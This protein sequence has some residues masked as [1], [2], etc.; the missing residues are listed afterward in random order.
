MNKEHSYN[1]VINWTGNIGTGTSNYKA[2]NRSHTII[3]DGKTPILGSSD[4]AF[5]G[6]A[7]RYNPEEL[8]VSSISACHMLWYLHLCSVEGVIVTHYEDKAT[9][10]M[11]ESS[12]GGG[13]FTGVVLNPIV[14]VSKSSMIKPAMELHKK[15]NQLCYIA[16]SLNFKVHHKAIINSE[17]EEID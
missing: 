7:S 12:D 8:L 10:I 4:P 2:Y 17:I 1:T 15:A 6:D 14:R 13:V 5:R 3:A 11:L 16:N 9:G